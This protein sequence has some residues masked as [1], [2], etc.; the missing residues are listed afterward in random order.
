MKKIIL[1]VTGSIAAY[2]AADIAN[3]LVK[4]DCDVHVVMT[5]AATGFLTPLTM[6][7]LTKNRVY[8]DVLQEDDPSQIVHVNLPQNADLLLIAPAT[9]NVIGKLACGIADD[10]LTSMALAAY[11]IPLLI[12][13]AMNTRMYENAAVQENLATLKRRGWEIIEPK[14]DRLACGAVGKGALADVDAIV[15]AVRSV[16]EHADDPRR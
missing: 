4:A 12:A 14:E 9:A 1:G 13:P 11:G 10:M 8:V 15:G 2:K 16:L 5:K 7:A 6:Q 3:R